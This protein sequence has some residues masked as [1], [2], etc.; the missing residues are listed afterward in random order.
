[1]RLRDRQ[2]WAAGL[3][4]AGLVT[5]CRTRPTDPVILSL[6]GQDVRRSE[7]ERYVKS[8][9]ARGGTS[10]A[11]DVREALL[12]SFLEERALVLAARARGLLAA[13]AGPD[14]EQQAV[15]RLLAEAVVVAVS[16]DE[17]EEYYRT[18]SEQFAV[19]ET[20]ALRQILV[21]TESEA[22]EV[23]RRLSVDP[24]SF[25]LQARTRSRSPEAANG[26]VMGSFARG[27]LPVE[28]EAAAFALSP[29]SLS[30]VV[31]S[32]LGFHIL[33]LDARPPARQRSLEECRAEI[34]A[35]LVRI[36]SD[37]GARL[38]IQG[39]LARAKVDHEAAQEPVRDS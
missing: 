15:Q 37:Q 21:A 2:L 28:L 31:Q 19:P 14:E 27:Q 10:L 20:V 25:D 26:G 5:T 22:R 11:G 39:L 9:E 13:S 33:K 7:F 38:F 16:E 17:V 18:H 29:G 34:R 30:E 12:T 1:M 8:V 24:K 6:D 3:M 36:K 23:K 32:P 35:Q 4:L